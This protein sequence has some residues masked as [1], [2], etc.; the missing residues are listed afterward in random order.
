MSRPAADVLTPV[1]GAARDEA[2]PRRALDRLLGQRS[3][4]WALPAGTHGG[5]TSDEWRDAQAGPEHPSAQ[6]A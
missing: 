5:A 3:P 6:L 1:P 4:A 2:R